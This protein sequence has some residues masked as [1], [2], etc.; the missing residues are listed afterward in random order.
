MNTILQEGRPKSFDSWCFQSTGFSDQW[1]LHRRT[2]LDVLC[3]VGVY[4]SRLLIDFDLNSLG[5]V[6][7]HVLVARQVHMH[8]CACMWKPEVESHIFV[9][10][11]PCNL[12]FIIIQIWEFWIM[13][14]YHI[15]P[16]L[17]LLP[18]PAQHKFVSFF[19]LP[20][21]INL[22]HPFTLGCMAFIPRLRGHWGRVDR[23]SLRASRG[24]QGNVS[25]V[26]NRAAAHMNS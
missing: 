26:H 5:K 17:Y 13:C 16:A 21:K 10:C 12:N 11:S 7:V 24:I 18:G 20:I 2:Q 19:P 9:Y 23:K 1:W 15:H 22:C 25:S 3:G 4:V 6:Y 14:F 8:V